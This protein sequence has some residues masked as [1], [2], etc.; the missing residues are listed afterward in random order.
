MDYLLVFKKYDHDTIGDELEKLSELRIKLV[1]KLAEVGAIPEDVY[2]TVRA[3]NDAVAHYKIE[4]YT[5]E[6]SEVE[7]DYLYCH[8]NIA[9]SDHILNKYLDFVLLPRTQEFET[10]VLNNRNEPDTFFDRM[11][12]TEYKIIEEVYRRIKR[13]PINSKLEINMYTKYFPC[14]SCQGVIEQFISKIY[15]SL[16]VEVIVIVYYK[17]SSSGSKN[18]IREVSKAYGQEF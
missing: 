12:D 13:K 1:E 5:N 14:P 2:F 11:Y 16:K 9:T 4:S 7:E 18:R 15:S 17:K 8:S 10:L 6:N 3:K